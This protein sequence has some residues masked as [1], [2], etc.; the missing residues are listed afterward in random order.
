MNVAI[1]LK[2]L[3]SVA[4]QGSYGC[5]FQP[6]TQGSNPTFIY[7]FRSKLENQGTGLWKG[8]KDNAGDSLSD[9]WETG[10]LEK[11]LV[12]SQWEYVYGNTKILW[13]RPLISVFTP[14][15]GM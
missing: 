15:R 2:Y 11:A 7:Y 9:D 6:K 3:Q 4:E 14:E 12:Y 5:G 8:T 10:E 1:Q 13:Q